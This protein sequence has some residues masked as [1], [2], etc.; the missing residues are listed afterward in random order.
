MEV[1]HARK[2]MTAPLQENTQ[3]LKA[4]VFFKRSA[5]MNILWKC[6]L[7]DDIKILT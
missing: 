5:Q 2:G 4:G 7:M 1:V 3:H 6:G